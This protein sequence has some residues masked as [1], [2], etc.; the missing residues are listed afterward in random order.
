[1]THDNNAKSQRIAANTVILFARMFVVM[2]VNLYAVRVVLDY[3]GIDDYGIFNAIAGVVTFTSFI[4]SVLELSIQRFYSVAIG[5]SDDKRLNE[6]FTLSTATIIAASVLVLVI[7]ETLGL[8]MLRTQLTIPQ[9]RLAAAEWCFHASLATFFFSVLQ[10][11]FSAAVF[12]HEKMNVYAVISTADSLLKL[13]VALCL[14][15]YTADRLVFYSLGTMLAGIAVFASYAIYGRMK[16]PEC[17]IRKTSNGALLKELLSFSGWTLL[18]SV[19]KVGTFQGSTVLLNIFFGPAAN[20]AFAVATQ[21]SNAFNALC[22]SMMLALRPAMIQA[23]AE[24]NYP[25]LN[26][27]FEI[28]NKFILYILLAISFPMIYEADEILR[29]WLP[30]VTPEMVVFTQCMI[31][32]IV[33]LALNNPITI[34]IQASGKVKE[35]FVPVETVS[36]MCLPL[37]WLFFRMGLPAS[38]TFVS[39]ILTCA[40]SH[41]IRLVCLRRN[42][43]PFSIKRYI[44]SLILPAAAIT[45]AGTL[46]CLLLRSHAAGTGLHLAVCIALPAG[47][48]LMAALLGISPKERSFVLNMIRKR[49]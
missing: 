23:Y 31:V 8:W 25:Y 13:L 28:S 7:M 24:K 19:A 26:S 27:L 12:A 37:T 40:L 22:N 2:L 16:F 4:N 46:F 32:Y 20:A 38:W 42:Y 49:I 17:R 45:A 14:A 10:I 15:L 1:M 39:M 29:I 34:I 30:H 18:G 9:E 6:I 47:I 21:V 44:R 33:C 43:A 36:L 3:L 11:P 5:E 35:Y 41:A 48:M